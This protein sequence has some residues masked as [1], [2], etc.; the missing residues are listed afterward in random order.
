MN[1]QILPA[2]VGEPVP[3][4]EY[5]FDPLEYRHPIVEPFRGHERSGLLTTPDL[6]VRQADAAARSAMCR[7]R[8]P[9]KTA[10]R[11]CWRRR[12]DAAT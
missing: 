2:Q 9:L 10:I 5:F 4:G 7:R 6:E 1:S 12:S 11:P 3:L 8:W